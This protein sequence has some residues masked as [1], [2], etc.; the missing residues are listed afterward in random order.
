[1]RPARSGFEKSGLDLTSYEGVMK[2]TKHG[3]MVIPKDPDGSNL[4]WLLDHK[5]S[6][7]IAHAA[8]RRRSS[9]PATA[10][11]SATG[12]ARAR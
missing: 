3:K 11:T 12:S 4:M 6:P 7:Q 1:M 2:G 9:P 10:T 5:V 8:R